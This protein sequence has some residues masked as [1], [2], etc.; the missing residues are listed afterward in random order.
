M[1]TSYQP[2]TWLK[3]KKSEAKAKII[4]VN[5]AGGTENIASYEIQLETGQKMTFRQD[6]LDILFESTGIVGDF[7]KSFAETTGEQPEKEVK[8]KEALGALTEK[9]ELVVKAKALG[10]KSAHLMSVDKLKEKIQEK[11]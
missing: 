10:I 7:Y 1:T 8:P 6:I 4:C 2:Y 3:P 5:P 11:E 9:G